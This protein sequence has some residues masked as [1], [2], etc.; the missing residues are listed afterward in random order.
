MRW[1]VRRFKPCLPA[2][3]LQ[4]LIAAQAA[5]SAPPPPCDVTR[6]GGQGNSYGT[7]SLSV[8][9]DPQGV[10]ELKEGGAAFVQRDGAIGA[11]LEWQRGVPGQMR[12][13][14]RRL[15]G[16]SRPLHA[17]IPK[18]G[19]GD[20]GWLP[21]YVLF[22]EP[23]SGSASGPA[24]EPQCWEI[25]GR[26]GETVLTF[27]TSL[28]RTGAAPSARYVDLLPDK[29]AVMAKPPGLPATTDDT[30][31]G[32]GWSPGT[33]ALKG[34]ATVFDTWKS[35]RH[36]IATL[37]AG[38]PVTLLSGLSQVTKPDVIT[39]NRPVPVLKLKPGDT[40]L[41]YTD[42]GEG[43]ADCWAN[44]RWFV[45]ADLSF[46][47]NADRTACQPECKAAEVKPGQKKWWFQLRLSDGRMG[48]TE[49]FDSVNPN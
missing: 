3:V 15:D 21:S 1:F 12:I 24:S 20:T 22:P 4:F 14:G 44:G 5:H 27:V 45:S 43:F 41:R 9:L 10:I 25:T 19:D 36:P 11:L 28:A 17:Q 31:P 2:L 18:S 29:V 7:R 8:V 23:P 40:L 30:L 33:Y 37:P 47:T 46:I 13:E 39:V 6:P 48:W 16:R 26:V 35:R 38:T 49:A 34:G 32:E 42:R